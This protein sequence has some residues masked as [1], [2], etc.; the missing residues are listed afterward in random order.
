MHVLMLP[1]W[2]PSQDNPINGSFFVE[3]AEALA[4]A[5]HRV[6]VIALYQDGERGVRVETKRRGLLT[7]Y[8]LHYRTA[9]LRLT[10][11]RVMLAIMGLFRREFAGCRPDV[12]HVH[13]FQRLP[14]ARAIRAMYG[15]PYVVTEHV[16]WFERGIVPEKARRMASAGYRR[17]GAVIAVSPGLRDTIRPLCGDREILVVPNLVSSRFFDGALHSPP[18]ETFGFISI[19]TLEHKKGMDALLRSFAAAGIKNAFLTIC[20]DGPDREALEQQAG[21]LGIGEQVTFTGRISREE[22]AARLRQN[23]CFVLPSRS[24]TF[25]VVF[26]EAMACGLPIIMTR[27]NAWEMLALPET[28]VAVDVD[29]EAALTQA[30]VHM[31]EHYGDYDPETIR[32]SCEKRFS[33]RAVAETLTEI[34]RKV[35]RPE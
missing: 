19:G 13:V 26:I 30:M 34:Y 2:Y 35:L 1:S 8:A 9:P 6:S 27:T 7:E 25:G 32:S 24:E 16:T 11:P 15:I 21:S 17:A 4:A 3:Q 33:E 23:Q 28:G 12:V 5:G 14:Y 22:V 10:F 18:G 20:G 29:D 31:T